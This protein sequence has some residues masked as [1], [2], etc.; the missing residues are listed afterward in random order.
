LNGG[1][2]G[3]RFLVSLAAVCLL[4]LSG[5]AI[6]S[7]LPA[8]PTISGVEV[9]EKTPTEATFKALVNGHEATT[10]YYFGIGT[11][12]TTYPQKAPLPVGTDFGESELVSAKRAG[13]TPGATYHYRAFAQNFEGSASS[14]DAQFTLPEWTIEPTGNAS[15]TANHFEDISCVALNFCVA[16]GNIQFSGNSYAYAETWNGSSWSGP[17]GVAENMG[18]ELKSVSCISTTSCVAVGSRSVGGAAPV[19]ASARWNGSAWSLPTTPQAAGGGNRM[20]GISC[21]S[22][23]FCVA[24]A[25]VE[26]GG[27]TYAYTE[28]W[29][30]SAW[31]AA[32]GITGNMGLELKSV[33]CS[34][35]TF[36]IAVGSKTSGGAVAA[37]SA[38]WNG[39]AW[40]LPTTP[41]AEGGGNRMTDV[42]CPSATF[43][44]AVAN[45]NFGGT[46][47]SWST[48]WNGSS[49]S[50][51]LG[52]GANL[53]VELTGVSCI[54]PTSSCVAVG[55]KSA[56]PTSSSVT[57][58]S[59]N[60]SAWTASPA[61]TT[62]G[63]PQR[64]TGVSC[65]SVC[66]AVGFFTQGGDTKTLAE[67]RVGAVAQA[68]TESSPTHV[69][70]NGMVNPNG[71]ATTFRFEYGTTV[72]YGSQ[73]PA[74]PG[75]VGSGSAFVPVS[76]E[77]TGLTPAATYYF[78][79]IAENAAGQILGLRS[80]NFT[81]PEWTVQPTGNAVGGENR[82]TG[83]S[84]PTASFCMAVAK[85]EAGSTNYAYFETWNGSGWG[86]PVS[87]PEN[88]GLQLVSVS[89]SSSTSCMAVGS[90]AIMSGTVIPI[91]ELW[92]G[93]TWT[94]VP[95]TETII[96]LGSVA[97]MTGVSCVGASFCLGVGEAIDG[98]G[99]SH[100]FFQTWD[101]SEWSFAEDLPE[102]PGLQL[103]SVSCAASNSCMAV[104][105]R[106]PPFGV[107]EPTVAISDRWNG[108]TWTPFAPVHAPGSF[109]EMTS[110]SCP[111][112]S[113]CL[114][115]AFSFEKGT[116]QAY[117]EAWGGSGWSSVAAY[118]EGSFV[119][120]ESVSCASSTSCMAV[121]SRT[122]STGGIA[123]I[124]ASW[125]GSKWTTSLVAPV[126]EGGALLG[127]SCPTK[128]HA[129]GFLLD[130]SGSKTLAET[131]P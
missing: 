128:C 69:K 55:T 20:T 37:A 130:G 80:G 102:N 65:T 50:V 71:T 12:G 46:S 10:S 98:E 96:E 95:L 15:G 115:V 117:A 97:R 126:A 110:V 52:T 104:G 31:S 83:V 59:W 14:P 11:N 9:S 51:V 77:L 62:G 4:S 68:P 74:T 111:G 1:T 23:S 76:T 35:T 33:S 101:G 78:R 120:L 60:G 6:S 41:Q 3:I 56:S 7:A 121:G 89:C 75:S 43:C 44:I 92:N 58:V 70:L 113:F 13:L 118:P 53:G 87:F 72:S 94:K 66:R 131:S 48:T 103:A 114:A 100:G 122:E 63:S 91:A 22:A 124:A 105:S 47:Y 27:T 30:G 79:L 39:T 127:V 82:M 49:W 129:V 86:A 42:S 116:S 67:T 90:K 61:A 107:V 119:G 99:E 108:T 21:V 93:S 36:C 123:P 38:R 24:V 17:V 29:N 45:L 54:A 32:A 112:V 57:A 64:F 81:T 125:N 28:T 16:V 19:A 73:S 25:F 84:C 109:S 34:S 26:S 40:S 8:P 18:L 88:T 85:V 2:R 106:T 5:A